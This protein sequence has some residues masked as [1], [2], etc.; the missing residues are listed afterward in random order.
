MSASTN[1][2][3]GDGRFGLATIDRDGVG[4]QAVVTDRGVTTLEALL[5]DAPLPVRGLLDDWDGW[6]DRIGTA[7]AECTVGWVAADEVTFAA[8]LQDPSNLSLA[9]LTGTGHDVVRPDGADQLD[10][11]VEP[12]VVIGWWADAVP[13]ED[14]LDVV[15]FLSR[16]ALLRPGDI[17]LTGTPAGKAAACGAFLADGDVITMTIEGLGVLV[18]TVVG[19]HQPGRALATDAALAVPA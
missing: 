8:P 4:T 18:N 7:L 6:C 5:Q 16:R 14:A 13:V 12:A 19:S 1:T 10:W 9:S 17:I 15:A 2:P 3:F 11:E